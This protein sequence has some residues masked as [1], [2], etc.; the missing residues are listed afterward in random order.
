MKFSIK[1][2]LN[3]TMDLVTFTEE[4]LNGKLHFLCNVDFFCKFNYSSVW[5]IKH[6]YVS[7]YCNMPKVIFLE[8]IATS[9]NHDSIWFH[10][11][12]LYDH[13]VR[14][15]R[16]WNYCENDSCFQTIFR[17]Y[18]HVVTITSNWHTAPFD[19]CVSTAWK[20]FVFKTRN[21]KIKNSLDANDATLKLLSTLRKF[22][23]SPVIQNLKKMGHIEL[24]YL[25]F[26][27]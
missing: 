25:P 2:F 8:K 7:N 4:I 24:T 1:D 21:I 19:H 13:S 23:I 3:V 27:Q 16:S 10:M 20:L 9:G 14:F 26:N 6:I 15:N 22:N 5:N 12:Y 18:D 17:S 11:T